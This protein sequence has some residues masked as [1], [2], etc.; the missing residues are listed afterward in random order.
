MTKKIAAMGPDISTFNGKVD[1]D[2]LKDQVD[3]V[4]IR[5]GYRGSAT[6]V[7]VEDPKFK[8]NIQGAI[9]AGLKVGIY[10]FSQAVNEVEAVEEASMTISLINK[11]KITYPVY[12]DVEAANGRGDTIDNATRTKVI[13]AYC[14]TLK[15]SGYTAG[16][17]AN[18]N[19]LETKFNVGELS[20]YKIWLAQYA[21]VPTYGGRYEMWQ[22]SSTGRISGISGNVDLNSSYM[23]Y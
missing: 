11:Y 3:F 1:F 18:K 17:Y 20:S 12:I 21:A 2:K 5:C 22:Y 9:N 10:F 13:R 16:I 23:T 4:I 6:G 14:Q 19:W 15:N 7:L 8:T